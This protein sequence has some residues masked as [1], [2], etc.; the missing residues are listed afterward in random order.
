MTLKYFLSGANVGIQY[1]A[2]LVER[3]E[4]C[5]MST[6]LQKSAS[7]K[8]RKGSPKFASPETTNVF[9]FL[10]ITP[11]PF[12][13]PSSNIWSRRPGCWALPECPGV[14]NVRL[15]K[16]LSTHARQAIRREMLH[17]P[18]GSELLLPDRKR[19]VLRALLRLPKLLGVG[20]PLLC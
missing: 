19:K 9:E 13:N 5:K 2:E 12:L 10:L 6:Q 7:P 4:C 3:E 15:S 17:P 11:S 1:S 14:S 20:N 16:P 8:A 18:E